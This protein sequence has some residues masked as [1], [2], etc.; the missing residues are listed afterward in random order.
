MHT[1]VNILLPDLCKCCFPHPECPGPV[2]LLSVHVRD[3]IL[4]AP[5]GSPRHPADLIHR[6]VYRPMPGVPSSRHWLTNGCLS[7][8][9]LATRGAGSDFSLC[10]QG[11]ARGP[12]NPHTM[13]SGSLLEL[14][15][16]LPSDAEPSGLSIGRPGQGPT[17]RC[18]MS[19]EE[20][21]IHDPHWPGL[22]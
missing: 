22:G 12:R 9:R 11:P 4:E 10:L 14:W 5:P 6:S 13:L 17:V 1:T 18:G 16:S 15:L 19:A 20:G 7:S 2:G 3:L 8:P 21:R